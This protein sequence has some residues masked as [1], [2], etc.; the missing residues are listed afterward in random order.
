[1]YTATKLICPRCQGG[2]MWPGGCEVPGGMARPLGWAEKVAR[3]PF[4]V[5]PVRQQGNGCLAVRV[6][7]LLPGL[8]WPQ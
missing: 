4:D 2:G 8:R 3:M 5:A 6:S 7:S 1:M